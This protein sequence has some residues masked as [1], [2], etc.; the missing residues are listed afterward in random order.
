MSINRTPLP[1]CQ[2]AQ[3]KN[4]R[5]VGWLSASERDDIDAAIAFAVAN[6][7]SAYKLAQIAGVTNHTLI[8]RAEKMGLQFCAASFWTED[9]LEKLR[10]WALV[11]PVPWIAQKLGRTPN[12][13]RNQAEYRRIP[14]KRVRKR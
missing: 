10:E 6:G 7:M 5:R 3:T 2:A 4:W 8:N 1:D 9:E 13:V 14:L 11:Y 12:A